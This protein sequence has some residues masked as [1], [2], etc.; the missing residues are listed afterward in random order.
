MFKKRPNKILVDVEC[1]HDGS[2]KH[3][4][5]YSENQD[6]DSPWQIKNIK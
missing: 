6:K 2:Y 1:S 3:I 5:K 4:L